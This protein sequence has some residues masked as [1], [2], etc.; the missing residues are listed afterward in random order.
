MSATYSAEFAN[1]HRATLT[2]DLTSVDITWSPDLP[3]HLKGEARKRFLTS[4]RIWRNDCLADYSA[5]TGL[6]IAVMEL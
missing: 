5:R 1:G 2:L 3:R 6:C 4:Y